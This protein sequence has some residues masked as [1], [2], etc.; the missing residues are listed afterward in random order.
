MFPIY[1]KRDTKSSFKS[2]EMRGLKS[3]VKK[4]RWEVLIKRGA[5]INIIETRTTLK[6]KN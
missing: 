3:E 6:E 5:Y 2:A 4:C 1:S